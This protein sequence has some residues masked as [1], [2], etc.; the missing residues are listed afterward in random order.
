MQDPQPQQ[1]HQHSTQQQEQKHQNRHSEQKAW[2]TPRHSSRRTGFNPRD[3]DT[4]A[5]WAKPPNIF[6]FAGDVGL[7]P[8]TERA[9]S[10]LPRTTPYAFFRFTPEATAGL[11]AANHPAFF[12][13]FVE[14]QPQ[15]YQH[16]YQHQ[17]QARLSKTQSA[18]AL[19]PLAHEE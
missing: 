9:A 2:R 10:Q 18:P 16:Q 17:E 15:Q 11:S 7:A 14:G 19:P 3:M 6:H 4:V 8:P 12:H 5:P 1:L 13:E